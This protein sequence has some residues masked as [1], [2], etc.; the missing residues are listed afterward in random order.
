MPTAKRAA[1]DDHDRNTVRSA[2][3]TVLAAAGAAAYCNIRATSI[4]NMKD[5]PMAHTATAWRIALPALALLAAVALA[6][7]STPDAATAPSPGSAW[8]A[9]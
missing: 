1:A 7:D 2:V 8:A 4:T 5:R 9:L 3:P 6:Q